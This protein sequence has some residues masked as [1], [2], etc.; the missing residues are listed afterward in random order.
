MSPLAGAVWEAHLRVHLPESYST[1]SMLVASDVT[2]TG[3]RSW[4][5][6]HC[7]LGAM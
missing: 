3:W 6:R 2:Q 4:P 7:Q 5:L 1:G